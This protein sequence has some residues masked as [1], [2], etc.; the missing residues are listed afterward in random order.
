[1]GIGVA[2]A[3]LSG[4]CWYKS[5]QAYQSYK[6]TSDTATAAKYRSQVT[7]WDTLMLVSAGTGVL[8]IG[9]SIPFFVLSPNSRD[10]KKELKRIETEMSALGNTEGTTK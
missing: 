5:D 8:S 6:S 9:G 7:L 2:S 10:E 1:M 3:G 4:V